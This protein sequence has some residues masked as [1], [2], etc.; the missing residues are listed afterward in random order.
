MTKQIRILDILKKSSEYLEQKN[1][2]EAR[3]SAEHLLCKVLNYA[4]IELYTNFEKPLNEKEISQMRELLLERAKGKPVQY[5]IGDTDFYNSRINV[6]EHV[7]IPR[8]ETEELV[9]CVINNLD[10][11]FSGSIL[12]IGTGSGA[13]AI[14]LAKVFPNAKIIAIDIS[15]KALEIA[16]DNAKLN[17]VSNIKF[18]RKDI[19]KS[20][21]AKEKFDIIVS[22]PPYIPKIDIPTLQDEVKK[23]EPLEALTDYG[24]GLAFYRYFAD[25]FH[26]LL[27]PTGVFFL[28]MGYDQSTKIKLFFK[29]NNF[30]TN[31]IEDFSSHKRILMG[32]FELS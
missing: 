28:E 12:D 16:Q 26:L 22:N 14:S 15:Q 3:L 6:N 24:D 27:K 10:S 29:K 1:I 32:S 30:Q 17:Q 4:R 5:I 2:G 23:F 7:L 11:D 25:N 31:I 8:P 21:E 13:I 9:E 20:G 18:F 19:F